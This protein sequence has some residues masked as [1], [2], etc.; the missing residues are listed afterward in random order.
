MNK[1]K[2]KILFLELVPKKIKTFIKFR[3]MINELKKSYKYDFTRFKY[4][5]LNLNNNSIVNIEAKISLAA[6]SLEKGLTN[7][8]FRPGFGKNALNNLNIA[9]QEYKKFYG[10]KY[11]KK[12]EI[13]LAVLIAYIKKHE[14][15]DYDIEEI[16]KTLEILKSGIFVNVVREELGGVRELFGKNL[17]NNS[18]KD[19]KTLSG[20]RYSIR[21]FSALKVDISILTNAIEIAQK[22]PSVCNRQPWKVH[23]ISS[24]NLISN[25]LE[26]QGG[27]SSQGN[28]VSQLL[29][30]TS[31]NDNLRS[32][33]EKNEGYV[34]CGMF[35]MSLLYSL[36][37]LGVA[38]CPLNANLNIKNE[39]IIRKM[40]HIG[41][42]E[43]LI[44]FIAVGNYREKIIVPV[45]CR[46]DLSKFVK[47][48]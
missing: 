21:D 28:N 31:D 4:S 10:N 47:Y 16:R 23:V 3:I 36:E 46:N 35:S 34:D 1:I 20:N 32:Y 38:T 41:E 39:K 14:E 45:S 42:N 48:Y 43:N 26:I 12:Y 37:Y 8:K 11:S 2:L 44:M 17:I 33:E 29:L 13:G 7:I 40:L 6:H 24:T 15:I 9:M 19:F 27:L 30:I 18:T 25:V 5:A 22:T